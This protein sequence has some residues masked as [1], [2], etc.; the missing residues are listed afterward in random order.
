MIYKMRLAATGTVRQN[1]VKAKI[2]TPKK[3]ARATTIL[4]HD[5]NSKLNYI[6]VKDSKTVSVLATEYGDEPSIF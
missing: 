6:T 3:A 2:D 4:L 5:R 1:R